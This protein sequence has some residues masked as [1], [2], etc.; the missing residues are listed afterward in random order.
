MICYFQKCY[1][2]KS[3]SI[4]QVTTY[5]IRRVVDAERFK[6]ALK[7]IVFLSNIDCQAMFKVT[8][9]SNPV[10]RYMIAWTKI[11]I[12]NWH[13]FSRSTIKK[14][15]NNFRLNYSTSSICLVSL[16]VFPIITDHHLKY[17]FSIHI[18]KNKKFI[19]IWK[20]R[21]YSFDVFN[22]SYILFWKRNH[23]LSLCGAV[24]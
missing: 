20:K 5:S 17:K 3:Q 2:H 22:I 7:D 19:Q 14:E 11:K 9:Q 23:S 6:I 13:N 12:H 21:L 4:Q 18:L 8:G 15:W 1:H 16:R 10:S 24:L